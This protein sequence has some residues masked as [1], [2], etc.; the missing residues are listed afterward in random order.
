MVGIIIFLI[1]DLAK[2]IY[3]YFIMVGHTGRSHF[4]SYT[5]VPA[6]CIINGFL[7]FCVPMSIHFTDA[8]IMVEQMASSALGPEIASFKDA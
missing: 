6:K 7:K 1:F 4:I 3:I 8:T 5:I 2:D